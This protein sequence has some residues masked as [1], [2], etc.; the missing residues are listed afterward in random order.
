MTIPQSLKDKLSEGKVLPFAGA[1][2]SMAV[3][4]K[5]DPKKNLF[6]SWKKLLLEAAEKLKKENKDAHAQIVEGF[7]KKIPTDYLAAAKEAKEGLGAPLWYDLLKKQIDRE[8]TEAEPASLE[9]AGAIWNLG[10]NLIVTTNYDKVLR[11][12]SPATTDTDEWHIEARVEQAHAI[13]DSVKRPTVWHL[14]GH[15]G[16]AEKII[17]SPDGYQRLYPEDAKPKVDYEAALKTLETLIVT[18][19]LLF[20]GFSMDDEYF[21]KRFD[22]VNSL[23]ANAPGPHYIIVKKGEAARSKRKHPKL[24]TVECDDWGQPL[25]DLLNELAKSA[26]KSAPP[27]A[28]GVAAPTASAVKVADYGPEKRPYIVRYRPKR[29]Q[30]IGIE[31]MLKKVRGQFTHGSRTNI[32]QTASFQGMGG[33]GKTQLAVEYA[34]R[35][36]QEYPNGVIW[37]HADQDIDAQLTEIA[38]V[39]KWVAPES[40]HK[41]KLDVAKHRLKSYSEC[42]IIFDNIE[43]LEDIEPYLPEPNATPHLLATSRHDLPNFNPVELNL[44]SS[45]QAVKLLLQESNRGVVEG[46]ELSAVENIVQI[47]G[48][49]PLAIEIAGAYLKHRKSLSFKEYSAQLSRNLKEALSDKYLAGSFTKHNQ[50]LFSTLKFNED[51][52][53]ECPLL[54]DVLNLLAYSGTAYMGKELIAKLL[55]SADDIKLTDALSLG[56][57]LRILQKTSGTERYMLHRLVREVRQEDFKIDGQTEWINDIVL[58]LGE[59][60]QERRQAFTDLPVFEAEIDHL[61]EWLKISN[62]YAKEH[63]SRLAWLLAYPPYHRG[64]YKETAILLE[65]AMELYQANAIKDEELWANLLNDYGFIISSLGDYRKA[66]TYAEKAMKI[67]E[68]L[69]GEKHSDTAT[70]YNSVGAVYSSLGDHKKAFEYA[71]KAMKIYEDVFGKKHPDTA[72]SYSFI[73]SA[74]SNLGEFKKALEYGENALNI[75][76]EVLGEKHPSTAASYDNVGTAY[77]ELNDHKK[78]FDYIKKSLIIFEEVFGEKHPQTIAL[79][80]NI[81]LAYADIGDYKKSFDYLEKALKIQEEVLGETHPDTVKTAM[82]FARK[83]AKRNQHLPARKM[84]EDLLNKL[85]RD[86]IKYDEVKN[87]RDSIKPPGFRR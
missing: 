48:G 11:W 15:I 77:A 35:Y 12:A 33:L 47:L 24:E 4:R 78:A 39:A 44:L 53:Q 7:L 82:N 30:V 74:Y 34:D 61:H 62:D 43:K 29:D 31:E 42:L 76:K 79:Y 17:L 72:D 26:A 13:R 36:G 37:I 28:V 75:Q 46:D 64:N 67:R 6:P 38:V 69:F 27:H 52:Y 66:F 81:G 59:W 84:L 16:N 57:D 3:K 54:L 5:D 68:E 85:P 21:E 63:S 58:R 86:H 18:N 56:T 60:F 87:L 32:G 65:E 83:K 50:G 55:D 71:E 49:L 22:Y 1:G 40:E 9:L 2:V 25:I 10:S 70:S 51:S 80:N 41:V 20:I 14:H 73:S 19:S 45:E 8:K 23:F